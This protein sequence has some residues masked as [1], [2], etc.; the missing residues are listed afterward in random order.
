MADISAATLYERVSH[1]DSLDAAWRHLLARDADRDIPSDAVRRFAQ[2]APERLTRLSIELAE[3]QYSPKPLTRI[4]IP[5]DDG[6]ERELAVPAVADRVVERSILMAVTP[7]A[8]RRLGP[9]S[10]A[11]R[12][13]IGVIDAITAVAAHRDAGAGWVLRADVADCF[14]SIPREQALRSLLAMLPDPS[15]DALIRRMVERPVSTRRGLTATT[16]VPQGTA[17]S[18]LL[19]NIVLTALDEAI[20]DRGFPMIRYA[21]DFV[22]P[23]ESLDDAW[24]A[25]RVAT[26]TLEP[27][28]MQL[29]ADKTEVMSFDEGFHFLGE[30]FGPRYPPAMHE[31][32]QSEPL[33]RI[34]YVARQGCRIFTRQG[35]VIV[36][37]KSDEELLSVPKNLVSR[38]VLFG[39]ASVAAGTR[40]WALENG[41]DVVFLSRRGNY[42]GQHLSAANGTRVERLRTQIA[43]ADDPARALGLARAMI[44]AKVAH[45]I[46]LLRR[47]TSRACAE[48]VADAIRTMNR[49]RAMIP[50][51]T[52]RDQLLGLEGAAAAAYFPVLGVLVPAELRFET[53]SRRPPLDVINSALGYGY[54]VLLAEC[55]AALV[56]AGLDPNIG[57]L[58]EASGKR[59]GLALD[60][61]EEWRPMIIDQVVS[62]AARKGTLTPAHGQPVTGEPGVH[63]TKSGKEILV[64]GYE[65]RML[66]VTSGAIPEFTGTLRRHLYRQ[67][68][69]LARAMRDP[70]VPWTGMSWR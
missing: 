52:D 14:D 9:S 21:D 70:A 58:H 39:S 1:P 2:S 48:P 54:A 37:S 18:P 33:R 32:R 47:L 55:V 7:F 66:Q 24:E 59:P 25:K 56:A 42:Q 11:Y 20:T 53:R 38:I 62:A 57:V 29:G 49:S 67:A 64:R 10:Y 31:H 43:V 19:A 3:H 51:A 16:G 8:D 44:D 50:D 40:S 22:V 61:M 60:L 17:L 46:T 65:R 63:L 69:L 4:A 27:M 30:D 26:E 45:Q 36:E 34:L 15:L 41:I 28:G 68:K 35:R 6:S 23:T 12:E 5:K 13:G